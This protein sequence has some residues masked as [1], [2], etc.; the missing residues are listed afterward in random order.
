M[1]N[2][3]IRQK[4]DATK[5]NSQLIQCT[6]LKKMWESTTWFS[7]HSPPFFTSGKIGEVWLIYLVGCIEDLC[8]L[9]G[10]SA[11]S[12]LRSRRK[13][14]F[15]IVAARPGIESQTSCSPGQEI[16]HHTTGDPRSLIDRLEI[17]DDTMLHLGWGQISAPNQADQG[18][19]KG[20]KIMK[21]L[22]YCQLCTCMYYNRKNSEGIH[23]LYSYSHLWKLILCAMM[24][25]GM[26]KLF[27]GIYIMLLCILALLLLYCL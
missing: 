23:I 4:Y 2:T 8:H 17:K 27:D 26:P 1:K 24:C 21:T 11:I 12:R 5:Y 7:H 22:A 18:H 13:P 10:I 16:N 9:S 19:Y 15:E 3:H 20:R 25:Q 14:I 6:I